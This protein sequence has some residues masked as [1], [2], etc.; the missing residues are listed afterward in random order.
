MRRKRIFSFISRHETGEV[1]VVQIFA[2]WFDLALD[3]K[4]MFLLSSL[5]RAE[6]VWEK[7]SLR[8]R[9]M[10]IEKFPKVAPLIFLGSFYLV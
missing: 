4:E 2:N 10:N 3:E 8:E 5:T 1:K 6:D 7:F 9:L